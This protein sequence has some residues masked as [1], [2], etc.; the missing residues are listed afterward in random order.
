MIRRTIPTTST[1][2]TA[3]VIPA[4]PKHYDIIEDGIEMTTWAHP[5]TGEFR[6]YMN[7]LAGKFTKVYAVA[8]TDKTQPGKIV[9]RVY[10]DMKTGGE[11]AD[12][13]TRA[14]AAIDARIGRGGGWR[15]LIDYLQEA[16]RQRAARRAGR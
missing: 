5:T 12:I 16:G 11:R 7:G 4:A 9:V 3:T 13:S 15:E 6:V 10:D 8:D 2:S 1:T 14:Y